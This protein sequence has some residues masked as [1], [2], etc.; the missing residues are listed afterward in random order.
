MIS[1]YLLNLSMHWWS[2]DKLPKSWKLLLYI[3]IIIDQDGS[4]KMEI[5]KRISN[6]K[7]V[8]GMLNYVL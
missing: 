7:K 6:G 5:M 4:P 3:I 2:E 1:L 8:T